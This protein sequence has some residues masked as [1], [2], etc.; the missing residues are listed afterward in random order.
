[1]SSDNDKI[2]IYGELVNDTP[3]GYVTSSE[4][5]IDKELQKDQESINQELYNLSVSEP[6]FNSSPA[7]NITSENISD[8]NS[9]QEEL[10]SG[11]N[12]K[13]V[14]NQSVLGSGNIDTTQ[15]DTIFL[16]CSSAADTVGKT[17]SDGANGYD[18]TKRVRILIKMTYSNTAQNIT[19]SINDTEAKPLWY[20][21]V[22]AS[23]TNTWDAGDVLDVYYDGNVY[24]A[25]PTNQPKIVLDGNILT[26]SGRQFAITPVTYYYTGWANMSRIEFNGLTENQVKD[27]LGIRYNTSNNSTYSDTFGENSLFMLAYKSKYD[28]ED[29]LFTSGGVTM[30]Q[31]L[32][33]DN[34][35]EHDDITIDG[36]TYHIWGISHPGFADFDPQDSITINFR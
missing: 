32:L 13:T 30:S 6:A 24:Q 11:T 20:G 10:E 25:Y 34:T 4:Q 27:L 26:I 31:N 29:I 36:E 15:V 28:I 33:T 17:I 18:L 3:G 19:L 14:N 22:L 7:K 12:I 5:I 35:A 2:K 8:W 21:G 23:P 9:K 16:V 1:M